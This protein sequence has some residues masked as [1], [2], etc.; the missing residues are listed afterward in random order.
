MVLSSDSARATYF[1]RQQNRILDTLAKPLEKAMK[2]G[3]LKNMS[4]H[5]LAHLL[6]I[7]IKG[8]QM[9]QCMHATRSPLEANSNDSAEMADILTD[10]IL[11]GVNPD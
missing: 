9:R 3:D 1:I 7:N 4:P 2:R 6:F 10:F 5:L 11:E 8:C